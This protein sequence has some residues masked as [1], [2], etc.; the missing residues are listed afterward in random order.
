M[1]V[2]DRAMM[3]AALAEARA[4]GD[5]GEVPVG[6][7]IARD[8]VRLA[9]AGN[10]RESRG[11]ATAHAEIVAIRDAGIALGGW[12]LEGATA[13]VTL[14]PCPM[15]AGALWQARIARLVFAAADP[16]AGAAGSVMDI[17]R[18]PRLPHRVEVEGGL[19]GDEAAALLRDFFAARR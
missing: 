18:S 8:G 6:C 19:L 10:E 4:A 1:S 9:A 5:R 13:Y 15:C 2:D 12:R 14:E 3:R 7:V 11:D 16:K 17:P